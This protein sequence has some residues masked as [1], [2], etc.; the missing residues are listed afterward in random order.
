MNQKK[1]THGFSLIEV[2]VGIFLVAVAV[3]GLAELFLLS[4]ANNQQ[5]DRVAN[6]T[7]LAQQQIDWLRGFTLDELNVYAGTTLQQR[8][9]IIDLNWDGTNDFRR[10]TVFAAAADTFQVSIHVFS[11]EKISIASPSVLLADPVRYRPRAMI[12][13]IITR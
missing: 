12:T 6:A 13:T 2:L 7:F 1:H 5:A 3:L 8:D 10:I 11:A 9:E 4:V